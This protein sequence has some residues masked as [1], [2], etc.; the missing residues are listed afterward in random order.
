M[1]TN[2]TTLPRLEDGVAETIAHL[3]RTV[4]QQQEQ[5]RLERLARQGMAQR[6]REAEGK[7]TAERLAAHE[8]RQD[9]RTAAIIAFISGALVGLGLCMGWALLRLG[10]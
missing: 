5:L 6:L 9:M 1:S 3:R 7:A 8:A 2:H 10:G 4:A